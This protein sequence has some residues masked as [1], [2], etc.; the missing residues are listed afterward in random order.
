[1]TT[2][3]EA[4]ASIPTLTDDQRIRAE[5]DAS[6]TWAIIRQGYP[7][8]P[9][10]VTRYRAREVPARLAWARL[11]VYRGW[12]LFVDIEGRLIDRKTGSSPPPPPM[13]DEGSHRR[14][15]PTR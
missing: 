12:A 8:R 10:K 9:V 11:T 1:M 6:H 14:H 5:F 13:T 4:L 2:L 7:D 15:D 3:R